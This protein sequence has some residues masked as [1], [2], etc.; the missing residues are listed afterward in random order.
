MLDSY[1][2][3]LNQRKNLEDQ[4]YLFLTHFST[5][6]E[7]TARRDS[8]EMSVENRK[9]RNRLSQRAFR[10]R[11]A[12][13]IKELEQR[14]DNDNRPL[15]GETGRV[16]ELEEQNTM[17]RNQLLACNKKLESLQITLKALAESTASVLDM[18]ESQRVCLPHLHS[19]SL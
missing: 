10:A 16:R 17:L 19:H 8:N 4:R 14:L 2:S 7:N 13:R 6:P 9:L 5:M 18:G 15:S 12:M 3:K 11:Q 1:F